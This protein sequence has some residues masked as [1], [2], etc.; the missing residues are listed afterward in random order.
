MKAIVMNRYGG[1][2]LLDL[3][4]VTK[5]VPT[6]RQ[7]LVRVV[8]SAVD[9]GNVK[10]AAGLMRGHVPDLVFPWIPGMAVAGVVEEIGA[11]VSEFSAGDEVYGFSAV[12]GG[13][14]EYVILEPEAIGIKPRTLSYGQAASLAVAGQTALLALDAACLSAGQRVLVLGAGGAVGSVVAQLAVQAG[15]YVIAVCRTRSAARLR[16]LG[17]HDV[18]ISEGDVIDL[19]VHEVDAVVDA[20]GGD[21]A[22]KAYEVLK[23]GGVLVALTEM[24]SQ[25]LAQ[26]HN[27][28]AVMVKTQSKT[29]HLERLA[30]TYDEGKITPFVGVTYSLADASLAWNAYCAKTIEGKIVI[31]VAESN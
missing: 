23:P 22:K 14:G 29:S 2:D 30:T 24:P 10:R 5:P 11:G 16:S 17:V 15:A 28:R 6:I 18:L 26:D 1:A 20:V 4:E 13:Y 21:Q 27:V 7:I 3:V 8:A 19:S 9:P 25:T 31:A 12:G